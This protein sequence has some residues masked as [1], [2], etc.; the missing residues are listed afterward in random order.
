ML[1]TCDLNNA[2]AKTLHQ[3]VC[4][5]CVIYHAKLYAHTCNKHAWREVR[6][7]TFLFK[8]PI[9]VT[10]FIIEIPLLSVLHLLE[11]IADYPSLVQ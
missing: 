1:I 2:S 9:W 4:L 8:S 11:T 10:Y 7:L 5:R 6:S 3:K